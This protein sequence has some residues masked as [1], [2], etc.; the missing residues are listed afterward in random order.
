M[1]FRSLGISTAI[2][3]IVTLS[4]DGESGGFSRLDSPSEDSVTEEMA[5]PGWTQH[6]LC[7]DMLLPAEPHPICHR[8]Y[9]VQIAGI[10]TLIY[11]SSTRHLHDILCR[12]NA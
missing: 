8:E 11:T 2:R 10:N 4:S 12:K 9:D 7:T 5:Q 1:L 3:R 6:G